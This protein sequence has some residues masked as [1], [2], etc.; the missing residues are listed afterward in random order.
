MNQFNT[1][2]GAIPMNSN[3][4]K[5]LTLSLLTIL[6]TSTAF[7]K[8][9]TVV[10]SKQNPSIQNGSRSTLAAVIEIA[11]INAKPLIQELVVDGAPTGKGRISNFAITK[12][13]AE[14]YLQFGQGLYS[15]A[16]I[17]LQDCQDSFSA[18]GVAQ[19]EKY[20][21]GF[22]GTELSKLICTCELK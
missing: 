2:K 17:S 16:K 19:Y 22:A 7:S 9:L 5:M 3:S 21:G 13:S 18:T 10:C 20:V 14:L 11:N 8:Q 6:C 15:S 12:D 1:F 4:M